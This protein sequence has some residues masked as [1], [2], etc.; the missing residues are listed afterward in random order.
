MSQVLEH[1][2]EPIYSPARDIGETMAY[3]TLQVRRRCIC[4]AG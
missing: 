4:D 3:Q 1:E 2:H